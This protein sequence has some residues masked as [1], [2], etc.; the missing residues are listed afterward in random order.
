M[1]AHQ[2]KVNKFI[3]ISLFFF[4]QKIS[5]LIKNCFLQARQ[6]PLWAVTTEH[7]TIHFLRMNIW[8]FC[9]LEWAHKTP[10]MLSATAANTLVLSINNT[11][12]W[13]PYEFH[14]ICLKDLKSE[15]NTGVFMFCAAEKKIATLQQ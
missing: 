14:W 7:N 6:S 2:Q 11:I 9:Y 8:L 10:Y 5:I 3:A 1:M 4:L 13:R 15:Q 12:S